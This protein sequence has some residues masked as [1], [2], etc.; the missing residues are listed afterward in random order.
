LDRAGEVNRVRV[1]ELE[2]AFAQTKIRIEA[3][4]ADAESKLLSIHNEFDETMK[5]IATAVSAA[6]AES[7]A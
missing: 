3:E 1:T 5:R 4:I 2:A 7:D 6:V